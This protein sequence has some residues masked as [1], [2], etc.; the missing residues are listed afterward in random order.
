MISII[1]TQKQLQNAC[2]QPGRRVILHNR[3]A[4]CPCITA[5]FSYFPFAWGPAFKALE[6]EPSAL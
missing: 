1:Y 3:G 4:F 6:I 2:L 5:R